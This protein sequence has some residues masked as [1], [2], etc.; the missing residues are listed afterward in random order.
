MLPPRCW[1]ELTCASA[2][3]PPLRENSAPLSRIELIS[4]GALPGLLKVTS[5]YLR[6]LSRLTSTPST[7]VVSSAGA[8]VV[9]GGSARDGRAPA[10]A[11]ISIPKTLTLVRPMSSSWKPSSPP[12]ENRALPPTSN[13]CRPL[14][15]NEA[16]TSG[17]SMNRTSE[18]VLVT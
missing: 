3:P 4:S 14:T 11:E 6:R 15:F 16:E 13:T 2:T 17:M 12:M 8:G 7:I 1:T 18:S 9:A 5:R 10:T